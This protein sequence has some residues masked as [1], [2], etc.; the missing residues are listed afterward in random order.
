MTTAETFR[1]PIAEEPTTHAK[2]KKRK[3]EI[4]Y[5]SQLD[6]RTTPTAKTAGG[7]FFMTQTADASKPN[8][9]TIQGHYPSK[10]SDGTSSSAWL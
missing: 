6:I 1:V 9:V 2:Q 8:C 7:T 10:M 5:G 3:K 4:R